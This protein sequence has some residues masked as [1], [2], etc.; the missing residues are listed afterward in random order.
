MFGRLRRKKLKAIGWINGGGTFQSLCNFFLLTYRMDHQIDKMRHARSKQRGRIFFLQSNCH[1][2]YTICIVRMNFLN[3]S[4]LCNTFEN[5]SSKEKNINAARCFLIEQL[6]IKPFFFFLIK[7]QPHSHSSIPV[8]LLWWPQWFIV[9]SRVFSNN[10]DHSLFIVAALA[11]T[12][13]YIEIEQCKWLA[14]Q[15]KM[16]PQ[17]FLRKSNKF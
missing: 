2:Q 10:A 5:V 14:S 17:K 12:E 3:D 1:N 4:R 15:V 13:A 9:I 11:C 7:H 8:V 6:L 16:D